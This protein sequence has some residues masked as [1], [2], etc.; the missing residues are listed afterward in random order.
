MK[1]AIIGAGCAGLVSARYCLKNDLSCDVFEQTDK[2]GGVWNYTEKIG[3]DDDG[4]PIHTVMYKDLRTNLPKQLMSY[5]DFPYPDEGKSFLT[6]SEVLDYMNRYVKH[7]NLLPVMKFHKQV[8]NITPQNGKWKLTLIDLKTKESEVIEDYDSVLICNGHYHKP[9]MPKIEG[10]K[11]KESEVIEDYDSVLICNGHYHKPSMPKIEGMDTFSGIQMHSNIYHKPSMP[12]IEGMDTFSGIQMHSNIYRSP[13]RFSRLKVLVIGAGP[14]GQDIASKIS[15]IADKVFLSHRFSGVVRVAPAV[16]QKP[17][18]KK[19]SDK[20]K[21]DAI[22]YCTGYKYDYPFLSEDCRIQCDGESVKYL[23]KH[24]I[25]VE[26]P[27]MGFLGICHQI[28]PFPVCDVQAQ[29]FLGSLLGRFNL[30]TKAEMIKEI[31]DGIEDGTLGKQIHRIAEKQK[32]YCDDLAKIGKFRSLPPVLQDLYIYVR[33][34]RNIDDCFRII[35]ENS[36]VK[37]DCPKN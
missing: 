37:I 19:I 34:N 7:F 22:V 15:A 35:D 31:R 24:I 18:V 25:N 30:K 21:I 33:K 9:S 8:T 4:L 28:C 5:Y 11:T 14:S 6:Q 36:Y 3:V 27:T 29:F 2:L 20:L 23:Y 10:T 1:L 32:D 17:V 16:I 12:K 13:E 26:H